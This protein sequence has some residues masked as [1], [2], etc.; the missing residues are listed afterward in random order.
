MTF[1]N[2]RLSG[3][4]LASCFLAAVIWVKPIGV[5]TQFVIANGIIWSLFDNTLIYADADNK[6]GV[7]SKNTYLNKSGGKYAG[8]VNDPL[9][10]SFV[11]VLC[12]ALGAW[13]GKKRNAQAPQPS[14]TPHFRTA[15]VTPLSHGVVLHF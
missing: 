8:N 12:M 1:W 7:A 15:G 4:A 10:Y 6:S 2:W 14:L 11:F 3:L 9:N 13:L 5:S